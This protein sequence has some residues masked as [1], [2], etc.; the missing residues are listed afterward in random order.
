MVKQLLVFLSVLSFSNTLNCMDVEIHDNSHLFSAISNKERRKII[1]PLLRECK[2][3]VDARTILLSIA[4]VSRQSYEQ[5]S[6][7]FFIRDAVK[8]LADKH[9]F[10]DGVVAQALNTRASRQYNAMG[11]DIF[12]LTVTGTF[13]YNPCKRICDLID[14]G[15]DINFR[16]QGGGAT[17][18]MRAVYITSPEFVDFLLARGAKINM[19]DVSGRFV[20]DYNL[21]YDDKRLP[22]V[23]GAITKCMLA[24]ETHNATQ[25]NKIDWH[26]EMYMLQESIMLRNALLIDRMLEQKKAFSGIKT[27]NN[28]L[29]KKLARNSRVRRAVRHIIEANTQVIERSVPLD[30]QPYLEPESS[31]LTDRKK[32]NRHTA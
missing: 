1:F 28:L 3:L 14:C 31:R 12:E 30:I 13:E 24:I 20:R 23:L 6:C 9:D 8:L 17:P 27:V 22:A 26:E 19:H 32:K 11:N 18:L 29:I 25:P 15:G 21:I 5:I 2:T 4:F 7:P 16:R 10:A